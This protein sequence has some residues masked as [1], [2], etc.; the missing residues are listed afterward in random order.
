MIV[1]V[2]LVKYNNPGSNIISYWM[3]EMYSKNVYSNT[4]KEAS[5]IHCFSR[6]TL[7]LFLK[8]IYITKNMA[9]L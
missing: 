7:L 8:K 5:A 2:T 6:M 4:V 3:F 9:I 1:T